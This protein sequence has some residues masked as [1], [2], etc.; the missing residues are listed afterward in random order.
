MRPCFQCG[1][2]IA[3][4]RKILRED[5]CPHC[6]SDLH[7]CRNCELFDPAVS[8][9]CRE[10]QADWVNDKERA[11]FCEFFGF[12]EKSRARDQRQEPASARDAFNRLFKS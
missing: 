7:C 11:N 8:N 3:A 9:Q 6:S 4:D 12:A 2:E 5:E 10:P 1:Q